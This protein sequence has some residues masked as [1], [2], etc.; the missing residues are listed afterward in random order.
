MLLERGVLDAPALTR[1][2]TMREAA[3]QRLSKL[4]IDMGLISTD[5]LYRVLG[6]AA[7][8]PLWDGE[9]EP[10]VDT[11]FPEGFLDYNRILPVQRAD[12]VMLVID[13]I[14]D[15]GLVDMLQR[16][17]PDAQLALAPPQK[18]NQAL[19][20]LFGDTQRDDEAGAA[21]LGFDDINHLKDLALEAPIVRMVSELMTSGVE[22]GASDI[23][24]EPAKNRIVL[25]YRVDGVLH[26]RPPPSPEE[27]PAVVVAHQDSRQPRHCRAAPAAGW[28]DSYAYRGSGG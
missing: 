3:P 10:F 4:V 14:E 25:R 28:E 26:V 11:G 7:G 19:A 1:I 23:H 13:D 24:L 22:M 9:G 27:F 21:T 6:E 20:L 12:N 15:D 8:F 2:E 17:R 16:L 5:N 18:L